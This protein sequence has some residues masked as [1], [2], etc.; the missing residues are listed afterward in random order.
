MQRSTKLWRESRREVI[1]ISRPPTLNACRI[2]WP[3][4]RFV[5]IICTSVGGEIHQVLAQEFLR[6]HPVIVELVR[7]PIQDDILPFT[8]PVVGTSGRVYTEL[9]IPKGTP[10]VLSMIGYNL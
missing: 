9:P 6:V 10:V 7:T 2:W 3:L 1:L 8:K 5:R 4:Q